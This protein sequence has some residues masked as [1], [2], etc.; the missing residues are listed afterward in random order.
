MWHLEKGSEFLPEVP[1]K[2]LKQMYKKENNSKAKLR[3]LAAIHRKRGKSLDDV[4]RLLEKPRR[5]VH[6][7]LTYFQERGVSAKDS[8]KQSGRPSTLTVKQ[9]KEL[10]KSLEKGPPHNPKGLWNT[11]EVRAFIK[12]KYKISFVPQHIWRIL[13]AL[14]FSLQSPRKK[15][16][17]S[18]SIK[19]IE[20]F[21]KSPDRKHA[22]T[23]RKV[24]LWPQKMKQHL[25]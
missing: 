6:G 21:K 24:L 14:G 23:E 10:V 15:H 20:A 25:A 13:I 19:E 3:L 22:T 18:A 17:K 12:K 7:W 8:I 4:A 1:V 9:M 5:T 11:K 16:Y 2:K